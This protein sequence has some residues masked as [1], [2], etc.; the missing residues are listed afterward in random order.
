MTDLEG[1]AGVQQSLDW[2]YTDGRYYNKAKEFLTM[3]VNASIEG[4]IEA[5]ATEFLVADGDGAG[6]INQQLLNPKTEYV[7][8][9]PAGEAS[10]SLTDGHFD[11]A[12]W[13]GQHPMAGT[14]GGHISHTGNMG[15]IEQSINGIPVGEFGDLVFLA[16][17]LGIRTILATGCEAFCREAQALLP[18]VETVAVK[19]GTQPEP[20]NHLSK[21]AYRKHNISAI[22]LSPEE[23]RARI[24]EGAKRALARAQKED[25]GLAQ[26]PQPPYTKIRITRAD[27]ENPPRILKQAHP[28]S[29][30]EMRRASISVEVMPVNPADPAIRK[31]IGR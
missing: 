11:F 30:L 7:C 6:G 24:K 23:S 14:V 15:V 25:F 21:D 13:V 16:T 2:C 10:F 31:V 1:V 19:K 26:L 29:I 20:G 17:E 5:G 9:W 8:S 3:E 18:G 12:A 4:F 28:S 27:G 22:H